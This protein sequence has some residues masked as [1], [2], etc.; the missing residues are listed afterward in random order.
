MSNQNSTLFNLNVEKALLSSMM[1]NPETF[2]DISLKIDS[3]VFFYK[4]HRDLFEVFE[5]L[6]RDETPFDDEFVEIELRK[7]GTFN[8]NDLIEVISANPITNTAPYIKQIQA[9]HNK[10]RLHGLGLGIQT[11]IADYSKSPDDIL[12]RIQESLGDIEGDLFE[13]HTVNGAD[14]KDKEI[15]FH[16]KDWLPI[17]CS[18]LTLISA[19]GGVGKTWI[20]VQ[21][22]VRYVIEH[23]YKK[24]AY[25]WLSEDPEGV[26]HSRLESVISFMGL[27]SNYDKIVHC[28]DFTWRE[29]PALVVKKS[30][31]TSEISPIFYKIQSLLRPYGLIVFDPMSDFIGADEND[32]S[33]ASTFMKPF[34]QWSAVEHK[35][36]VFLHHHK[37]DG[38]FRGATTIRTSMRIAY[39]MDFVKNTKGNIVD[40]NQEMRNIRL[41]KDNWGG[42]SSLNIGVGNSFKRQ[43]VPVDKGFE[44]IYEDVSTASMPMI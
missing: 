42:G 20:A 39:E 38:G 14:L 35:S 3:K 23:K 32:N 5:S 25:L 13:L 2:E 17:P 36:I 9:L 19:D 27:S 10:R 16:C 18:A 21:L 11:D 29:P 8:Q 22:A 30:F 34:K 12:A 28:I 40:G 43:I 1:F 15:V 31:K 37:K 7:K 41:T 24:R 44:L 4:F 33:E 6:N 26:I